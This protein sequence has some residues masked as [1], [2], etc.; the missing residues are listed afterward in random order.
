MSCHVLRPRRR[1]SG[2]DHVAVKRPRGERHPAGDPQRPPADHE[3][4]NDEKM[5]PRTGRAFGA[6]LR[7]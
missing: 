6:H 2:G 4:L 5:E 3:A 7:A 1:R